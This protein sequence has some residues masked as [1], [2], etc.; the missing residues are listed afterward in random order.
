M[1]GHVSGATA[2]NTVDQFKKGHEMTF[3]KDLFD[4]LDLSFT[5]NQLLDYSTSEDGE[6][7]GCAQFP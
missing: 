5:I 7:H 1:D 3:T 2:Y 6:Q 4:K